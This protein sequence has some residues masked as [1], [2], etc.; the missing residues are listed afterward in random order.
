MWR[1]ADSN[2]LTR[3][4]LFAGEIFTLD[5][6][7]PERHGAFNSVLNAAVV[8]DIAAEPETRT[9]TSLCGETRALKELVLLKPK[10]PSL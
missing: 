5:T 10:R 9:K 8:M 2:A 4:R 7:E 3:S 6:W 1:K